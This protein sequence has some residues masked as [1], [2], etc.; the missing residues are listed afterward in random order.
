M[1]LRDVFLFSL[2]LF[3]LFHALVTLKLAGKFQMF[4]WNNQTEM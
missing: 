2:N 1:I 3:N 4:L